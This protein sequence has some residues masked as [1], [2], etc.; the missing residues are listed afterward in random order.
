MYDLNVTGKTDEV[1]KTEVTYSDD[2]HME[3]GPD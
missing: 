2:I 1:Y 3:F